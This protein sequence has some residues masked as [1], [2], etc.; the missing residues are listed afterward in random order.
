MPHA[1]ANGNELNMVM[2]IFS[3]RGRNEYYT[4]GVKNLGMC[5]NDVSFQGGI[6]VSCLERFFGGSAGQ[7]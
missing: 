2:L 4:Y 6:P 3:F 7:L 1:W 5:E